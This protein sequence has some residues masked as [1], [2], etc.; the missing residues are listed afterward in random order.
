MIVAVPGAIAVPSAL[1]LTVATVVLLELHV[2]EA[3]RS[4]VL[5]SVNIPV[6]V[7]CWVVPRA[8][9][10]PGGFTVI[11]T[12][13]ATL[14]VSVV[15]LET[16]P[17]VAEILE[18]P[19]ATLVAKP[20]T[21]GASPMVATEVSDEAHWT[22]P[23]MVCV[24]PSVKVPVATNCSV[25][26]K[27]MAGSAGVMVMDTKVAAVTLNVDAPEIPA[28]AAVMVHWPVATLVASPPTLTAGHRWRR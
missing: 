15:E 18:A 24:L 21:P 19:S 11:E 6:A 26:P 8:I 20:R 22:E 3:V 1:G 13:A 28:A 2:P 7:N 5:P 23:V 16:E 25:V 12:R 10:G 4:W 9:D 17:S 14:T 27:G